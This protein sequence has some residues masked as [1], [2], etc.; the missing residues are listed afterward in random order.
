MSILCVIS[1]TKRKNSKIQQLI[2][3]CILGLS[4]FCIALNGSR[5]AFLVLGLVIPVFILLHS[6]KLILPMIL[7]SCIAI[8]SVYVL[9]PDVVKQ[10][11]DRILSIKDLDKNTSN[12]SRLASWKE[13]VLFQINT[14]ENT[15]I[16]YITGYGIDGF[17][18]PLKKFLVDKGI[19]QHL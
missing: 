4:I 11:E 18:E 9:Y 7:F 13:G 6:K 10:A 14:I 19:F 16:T 2:L 5:A 1:L 3:T 12:S 17:S 15:P 8:S